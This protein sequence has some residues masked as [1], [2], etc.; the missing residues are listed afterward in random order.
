LLQNLYYETKLVLTGGFSQI[1]NPARIETARLQL[2]AALGGRDEN[3]RK[4]YLELYYP[5]Y[6]LTVSAEDR[7]RHAHFIAEAD[8][9]KKTLA[10]MIRPLEFE[11]V[12]EITVFA[13][14][15]PKLLSI[16]TGA[17][18]AANANI[19]DAQIFTTTDGRALDTILINREFPHDEDE[20]R[21]ATRVSRMIENMLDG[22]VR[23]PEIIRTSCTRQ[24]RAA[25]AFEHTPRVEIKNNFSDT[26]SVIEV[27]GLDRPGLLSELTAVLSSLSLNIASAHIN[28][29][30]EKVIDSFH[31]TD[32]GGK[33]ITSLQ[34]Q[35]NIRRK[36]LALFDSLSR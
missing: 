5:N 13:P 18:A 8:R 29:F 21:R 35:R 12:T 22:E 26:F 32:L 20:R 36:L 10:I 14:D 7:L 17:C 11:A 1:P 24:K 4:N 23:L 6:W 3:L 28:T 25:E 27:K 9:E 34:R 15:H 2:V 16:I 19:V 31:V 33:K 30:G